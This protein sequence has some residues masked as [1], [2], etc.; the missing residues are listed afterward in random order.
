VGAALGLSA[1]QALHAAGFALIEQSVPGMGTAYAGAAATADSVDT[2]F[3]NPAGMTRLPGMQAGAAVHLILLRNEFKNEGTTFSPAIPSVVGGGSEISGGDGGDAGRLSAVPHLY[4][5]NQLNDRTWLG[6][7]IN[8]PFGLTTDY[9]DGW[10]GRYHAL[11]SHVKTLNINPSIAFKATDRLSLAAGVSAMYLKGKFTNAVD[12]GLLNVIPTADGGLGG[13][14]GPIAGPGAVQPGDA[15]GKSDIEGDS[16]G[17]GF[18]LGALFELSPQTRI[19]VH[20]RSKVE[21]NIDGNVDFSLPAGAPAALGYVFK[22]ARVKADVDLPAMASVSAFHQLTDEW[23]VMADYTWT[24]WSSIPELRFDFVDSSLPDGVTTFDWKDTS[25]V[26]LG[27][28]YRPAG[29]AWTF[30]L[31]AAWDESPIRDA[32]S[33]SARLPDNDRIWLAIGAGFEA[34]ENLRIDIGYAHLFIDDPE[35]DKTGLEDEDI[36]R[37]ALKGSYDSSVDI[38]ALE[39]RYTF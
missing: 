37:G 39:A 36:T 38:L 25:R 15:D 32:A 3:F 31:G 8:V 13:L 30:R 21:Q 20:Y 11:R 27:T 23:A 5:T 18:N 12:F 10:V 19:G 9:D 35:I 14:L 28:T 6:L 34:S 17:F 16:W 1:T 2:L 7:A 22:D 33:R 29:S 4:L 24:G 26:S